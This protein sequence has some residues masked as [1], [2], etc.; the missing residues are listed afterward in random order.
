MDTQPI[1]N[2]GLTLNPN[3]GGRNQQGGSGQRQAQRHHAADHEP[4]HPE[5]TGEPGLSAIADRLGATLE[6]SQDGP[7]FNQIVA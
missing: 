1:G 7:E 5:T 2:Q 3:G 4:P 6:Q